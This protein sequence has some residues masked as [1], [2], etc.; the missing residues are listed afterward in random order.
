MS[1]QDQYLYNLHM[2]INN[3]CKPLKFLDHHMPLKLDMDSAD[4]VDILDM[5]ADMVVDSADMVDMVDTD[6]DYI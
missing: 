3:L 1:N 2:L 5:V 6:F 4:M